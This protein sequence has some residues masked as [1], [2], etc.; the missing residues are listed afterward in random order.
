MGGRVVSS[1][2]PDDRRPQLAVISA[3]PWDAAAVVR[4]RD[5]VSKHATGSAMIFDGR[6]LDLR[7]AD[8]SSLNLVGAR[9]MRASLDGVSLSEADLTDADLSHAS[10]VGTLFDRARAMSA[11]I[12]YANAAD[13]SFMRAELGGLNATKADFRRA[14]FRGADLGGAVFWE[15]AM[16]TADLRDTLLERTMFFDSQ[17]HGARVAGASGTACGPC[18]VADGVVL[19]AEELERW[20]RDRGADVRIVPMD[21]RKETH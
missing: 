15:C 1:G 18:Q 14:D 6:D 19:D 16:L 8:L 13:A 9:L 10:A 3:W 4:L 21:P 20:F 7:G 2:T 5:Y 12:S 11:D 17:L